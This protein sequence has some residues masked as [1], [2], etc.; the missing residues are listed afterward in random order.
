M[1]M[2]HLVKYERHRFNC[3]GTVSIPVLNEKGKPV[4]INKDEIKYV[5]GQEVH[6]KDNKT[7]LHIYESHD[8]II[9]WLTL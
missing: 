2:L 6:L 3:I 7:V 1:T 4:W 5:E 8:D 9:K